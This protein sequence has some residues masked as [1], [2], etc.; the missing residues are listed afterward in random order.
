MNDFQAAVEPI[1]ASWIE[2]KPLMGGIIGL[3]GY[4]SQLRERN[5]NLIWVVAGDMFMGHYIDSLT[6]GKAVCL[7]QVFCLL[8]FF[9]VHLLLHNRG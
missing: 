6:Q 3:A 1:K 2:G 8:A 5:S 9:F 7:Y 4:V